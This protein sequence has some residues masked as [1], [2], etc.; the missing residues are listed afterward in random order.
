MKTPLHNNVFVVIPVHNRKALTRECLLSLRRQTLQCFKIIV[1]D[2]GST[3]GT[4]E[5]I[6]SEFPDVILLYGDGNLW[7]TGA[8][9]KG[10]E[11]ALSNAG[12]EDYVLTLNDDISVNSDYIETIL[13]SALLHPGS[14]IGSVY[15]NDEGARSVLDAGVRI[16]WLTA[17][18]IKLGDGQRYEDILGHE[19]AMHEVDVL[20]GRGTLIPNE[21]F[22]NIGLYDVVNLPHYGADYEFSC[23]ARRKGYRLLINCH[24]IVA[25]KASA[26]LLISERSL[27]RRDELCKSFVSIRSPNCIRFRWNFAR[28]TCPTLYLPF[29]FIF[30]FCRVAFGTVRN[31]LTS[32]RS[33]LEK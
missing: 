16:N 26:T 23:R 11:Y 31:Q 27:S 3:D 4:A 33:A 6:G 17:K 15:L 10:V 28:L 19:N 30:D 1:V 20:S 25:C 32:K 22:R 24:A 2:D 21:V 29:F 14:L 8:I 13:A 12:D 5:M 18:F 7:W 9:N